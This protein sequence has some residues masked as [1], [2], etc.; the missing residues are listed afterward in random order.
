MQ[1]GRSGDDKGITA[2]MVKVDCPLLRK[3]TL[4]PVNAILDPSQRLPPD[5]IESRIAVLSK[6]GD[7][8]LPSNYRPVA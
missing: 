3:H 2:E 1:N 7:A 5:W 8:S 4:D 6:I